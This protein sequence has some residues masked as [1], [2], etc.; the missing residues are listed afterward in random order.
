MDYLVLKD[1]IFGT[2]GAFLGLSG[3]IIFRVHAFD[4]YFFVYRDV[5]IWLCMSFKGGSERL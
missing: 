2:L 1:L 3:L 5:S 4:L